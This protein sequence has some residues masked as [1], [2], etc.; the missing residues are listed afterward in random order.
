MIDHL[1][2]KIFAAPRVRLALMVIVLLSCMTFSCNSPFQPKIEFSPR[3]N[4]Y[5]L[6]I[7]ESQSVRVR[8]TAVSTVPSDIAEPVHDA[9]VILTGDG[10]TVSLHDT[11]ET[12]EGTLV[13]SYIG[14]MHIVSSQKYTITVSKTGYATATA[15]VIVPASNILLQQWSTYGGLVSNANLGGDISFKVNLSDLAN[16]TFVRLLLEYRGL[17]AQGTFR[18][19]YQNVIPLDTLNPF[20]ELSVTTL[21][22]VVDTTDYNRALRQIQQV[23]DSLKVFHLYGD[24]IVTQ[25]DDNLYRF[26]ITSNRTLNPLAMRTD[27]II[28]SNIFNKAGTGIVAGVSIDTTRV[29][30][31]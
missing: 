11:T 9:T 1:R 30:I 3:L 31:F 6:L 10:K 8:V 29:I 21:P 27:K 28:Y 4:I 25:I 15:T 23:T 18:N 24:I 26:F 16:A 22:V 20:T 13:S 5:A 19:G 7:A 12:Y 14:A 17:D 2:S